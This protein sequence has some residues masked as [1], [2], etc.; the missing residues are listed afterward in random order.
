MKRN[1]LKPLCAV[2]PIKAQS[3][4]CQSLRIDG[5]DTTSNQLSRE[6]DYVDYPRASSVWDD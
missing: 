3:P 1:Y 5:T 6:N 4:L 2:V